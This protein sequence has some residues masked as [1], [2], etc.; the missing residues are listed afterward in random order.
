MH[1]KE[2]AVSGPATA[3]RPLQR[4]SNRATRLSSGL[5]PVCAASAKSVETAVN[6][7]RRATQN[8]VA[9]GG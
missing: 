1:G 5:G 7:R 6:T 4:R 3:A 8:G 9:S 2:K